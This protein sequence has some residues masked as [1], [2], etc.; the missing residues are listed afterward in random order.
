MNHIDPRGREFSSEGIAA[1]HRRNNYDFIR[2]LAACFVLFSHMYALVGQQEPIVVGDYTFGGIGLLI[3]FSISGCLV[4][5]SWLNDPDPKRF[6]ARRFLRIWPALAVV[7]VL[8]AFVIAPNFGDKS[9]ISLFSTRQFWLFLSN[10]TFIPPYKGLA[11][12]AGHAISDVNGSL[13]TIPIEFLCYVVT[14][15]IIGRNLQKGRWRLVAAMAAMALYYFAVVSGRDLLHFIAS[16]LFVGRFLSLWLFFA[17]GAA[18]AVFLDAK[19]RL[20]AVAAGVLIGLLFIAFGQPIVGLLIALPVATVAVGQA[21]WPFVRGIGRW[22][23]FSYGLYLYAWPCQQ[24]V[25]RIFRDTKP[26]FLEAVISLGL[27]LI[28]AG[29]SWFMVERPA[30]RLKPRR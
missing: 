16:H 27:A 4:T 5:V 30:L 23:D 8:S 20:T 7:V 10:L 26:V 2:L 18:I 17:V 1:E 29:I 28:C 13:W 6:F 11:G 19:P 14:V 15:F 24:I 22:G 21:S 9:L 3:F 25:V 12:F